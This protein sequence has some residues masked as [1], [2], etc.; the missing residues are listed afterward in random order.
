MKLVATSIAVLLSAVIGSFLAV[1]SGYAHE[2]SDPMQANTRLGTVSFAISCKPE[3]QGDFNH[4][5]ALLHSF[6]HSEAQRALEAI[7]A[8]DPD[9]AMAY[10]GLAM[11]HLQFGL[12]WPSNTDLAAGRSALEQARAATEQTP[13]ERAYIAA[14]SALYDEFKPDDSWKS[15]QKYADALGQIGA[16]Y[17]SDVEA[18]VFRALVLILAQPPDDANL[19]EMKQAVL[20]LTPL[21]RQYPDHPG[22][23]H[24]LIHA[25]DV[26]GMAQGGLEAA[27]HYAQIAPAAPHALHMPSHIFARLGLWQEDIQSNLASKAA[28]EKADAGAENRLHAMEFLEYAYLQVG[29]DDEARAIMSEAKTISEADVD[30][31]FGDYYPFVQTRV[32]TIYAIEAKDWATAARL[33]PTPG[34]D[35]NG[36]G[37]TLLAHAMAAGYL[38]DRALAA[39]TL[40]ATEDFIKKR[41][42]FKSLPRSGTPE[43]GFIDEIH[44]WKDFTDGNVTDAIQLLRPVADR[45]A[46]VGKGELDLP[47][48]E[49][50]AEMLLLSGKPKEA[51]QEYE[52]SLKTDP[53]RFNALLGAGEAA[54]QVGRRDL[55]REYYRQLL[56]NC[57]G[58]TGPAVQ[59]LEH[60]KLLFA[61]ES[62]SASATQ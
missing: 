37:L 17:P 56:N 8:S 61:S 36:R 58:A 40:R 12:S 16:D 9:C 39:D 5:V 14:L 34:G 53:N 27:R 7:V 60:A 19:V 24:Y 18:K 30:P 33:E 35:N 51:L 26:P 31:R 3:L 59:A 22:I 23:A 1:S 10:W 2:H 15:F 44:A 45:E 47:V 32:R 57:A 42:K 55:A 11:S 4:A 46:K 25:S 38:K 48:R 49:M 62:S 50:L 21:L 6:W 13:R 54:E 28:A 29:H 20:I 41:H 43:A 52:L